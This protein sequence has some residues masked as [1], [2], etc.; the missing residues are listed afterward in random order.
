MIADRILAVT[1][2]KAFR[3]SIEKAYDEGSS[4]VSMYDEVSPKRFVFT[5]KSP[6]TMVKYNGNQSVAMSRISESDLTQMLNFDSVVLVGQGVNIKTIDDVE[7]I[8]KA[9]YHSI[10]TQEPV[11]FKDDEG[12]ESTYTPSELHCVFA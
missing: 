5:I 12:I 9:L 6:P 10:H 4:L 8:D 7:W 11:T 2:L 3:L 1:D